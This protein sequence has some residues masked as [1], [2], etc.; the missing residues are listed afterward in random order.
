M[1]RSELHEKVWATPISKLAMELGISDVGLAKACRRN[2]IP[3]PPRGFWAKLKAGQNPPRAPLP[4]PELDVVVHFA[5]SDPRERA[6]QKAMEEHR[7]E[8]LQA[9]AAAV[10]NRLPIAFAENLEGAH[11]LVKTT[12]RYCERIPKLIEKSRRG[13]IGAWR[14]ENPQDHLPPEQHG[15]YSLV[16][17]GCLDVNA[18]LESMDWV[19]RF[20]AT[21]LRGLSDGGMTIVRREEADGR[22][23]RRAS[24]PAVEMRFEGETLAFKFSEGY[25][26]V[27]LTPSELAE[28]RLKSSLVREYETRPSGN[29]TFS[30]EGTEYQASKTWQGTQ[31]KLQGLVNE[32]LSMAFQL[33]SL[34]PQLKREREARE[35]NARRTE[36][37]RAQE[38]RRR[39]ARVE[40]LKQAFV[41]MEAD[42]R[43]RQLKAFLDR[44]EQTA[45]KFATPYDERVKVWIGVVKDEL[46]VRNP[47]DE[48]LHKCLSVPSWS[49]WPPAWWPAGR[50]PDAKIN[51]RVDE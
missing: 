12:Q 50:M 11:P 21:L 49:T 13:G 40:Q 36:E 46:A 15:R 14:T 7:N 26:R 19:L 41:M 35:D 17:R 42:A 20:H 39:E 38:Y 25:R 33:A 16:H 18:S 4:A 34:Q 22:V 31:E 32:I 28:K 48:I 1:K 47:V 9:R 29:F 27:R 24:G 6:R 5:T 37:L 30:I 23:S 51:G 8:M 45:T 43:V 2:A 10:A 3:V 44:L